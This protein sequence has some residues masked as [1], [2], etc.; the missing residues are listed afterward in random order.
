ME[1]W[2]EIVGVVGDFPA[3]ETAPG[4]E[5]AALYHPAAPGSLNPVTFIVEVQGTRP[6]VFAGRFREITTALDPTLRLS[7]VR[8]L[9]QFYREEQRTRRLATLGVGVVALSVLL[10]SAAGIHALMSFIVARRRKEIGIRTALGAHPRRILGSIFARALRQLAL[11]V[12]V[13][14]LLGG[15]LIVG[16]GYPPGGAAAL[17]LAVAALVLTVGLLAALGPARRGLRIQPME[18]LREE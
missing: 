7:E 9:E 3:G 5:G 1:R 18:A 4:R 15:A 12:A 17:L 11:G 6:E 13:G 8:S 14:G 2:Y 16:G 10:L